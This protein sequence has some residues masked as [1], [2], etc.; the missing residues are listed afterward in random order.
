M[1]AMLRIQTDLVVIAFGDA[2]ELIV[3]MPV[4]G[5]IAARVGRLK[6]Y[7]TFFTIDLFWNIHPREMPGIDHLHDR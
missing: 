4:N 1:L 2:D 5:N 3:Q 7:P 6:Y